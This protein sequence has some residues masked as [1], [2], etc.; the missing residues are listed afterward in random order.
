[1]LAEVLAGG[2]PQRTLRESDYLVS[3]DALRP[4]IQEVAR[5]AY[6][7]RHEARGEVLIVEVMTGIFLSTG[8]NEMGA[9]LFGAH[10]AADR[11]VAEI[12]GAPVKRPRFMMEVLMHVSKSFAGAH[13]CSVKQVGAPNVHWTSPAGG[14]CDPDYG[15]QGMFTPRKITKKSCAR[16]HYD[17][18]G[19]S[20]TYS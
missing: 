18:R 13:D 4:R 3:F 14:K 11:A 20:P 12:K 19:P 10:L 17:G 6:T 2:R 5:S 7:S 16:L 8:C 15:I 9:R 1:M